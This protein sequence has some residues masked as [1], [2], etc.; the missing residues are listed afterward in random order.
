MSDSSG[1]SY[2]VSKYNDDT[3]NNIEEVG[4]VLVNN[5][6]ISHFRQYSIHFI[7]IFMHHENHLRVE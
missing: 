1:S 6:T 4:N 5:I 3:L 2:C 7:N